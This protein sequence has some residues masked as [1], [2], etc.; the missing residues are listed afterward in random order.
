M[1]GAMRCSL[2]LFC[3]AL[4][5]GSETPPKG[6]VKD[7][8]ADSAHD[9]AVDSSADANLDS[10]TDSAPPA[11]C[12]S[13]EEPRVVGQVASAALTEASGLVASRARPGVLW[14]HN[15]SGDEPRVFAL[16]AQGEDLGVFRL[17][18]AAAVDWEGVAL[19]PGPEPGRDYLYLGD[20]G[21][22]LA[23]REHVTVY[24]VAEP[25]ADSSSTLTEFAALTFS[26]PDGAHN[27]EAL[28]S[29]PITGDLLIL[30]K[31][32]LS[33]RIYRAA[34][35]HGAS[36]EPRELSYEGDVTGVAMQLVTA[37]DVS[38]AGDEV[39]VRTYSA[40]K[41]YRRGPGVTVAAAL[42]TEPCELPVARERQGET[43]TFSADG[44]AYFTVSEGEQ[45]PLYRYDRRANP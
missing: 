40:I 38:P 39:L 5:C 17:N 44:Q 24:R 1:T 16:G 42:M 28:L 34:A 29:D 20:I 8:A 13:F 9:S 23:R 27:A 31:G 30:T 35:P 36:A 3:L 2:L 43:V 32:V 11:D 18:G 4:G 26:Y 14:A 21:D 37:G 6:A 12:P 19:G 45:P 10:S 41:R 7:A 15:D 22:N 25:A 33:S